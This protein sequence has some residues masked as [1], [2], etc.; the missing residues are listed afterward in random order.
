MHP[1]WSEENDNKHSESMHSPSQCSVVHR[2]Q[3]TNYQC[4]KG[5]LV[6]THR[7]QLIWIYR[8][9]QITER[10]AKPPSPPCWTNR[11]WKCPSYLTWHDGSYF[12]G[13]STMSTVLFLMMPPQSTHMATC[14]LLSL[15]NS[16]GNLDWNVRFSNDLFGLSAPVNKICYLKAAWSSTM[17]TIVYRN[18][19]V[20]LHKSTTGKFLYTKWT[21]V[22]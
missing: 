11:T 15:C 14:L 4:D 22:L 18:P 16:P 1:L 13:G 3:W 21:V 9:F 8:S 12:S 6:P 7:N 5:A 19:K 17:S 2:R 10:S 20:G